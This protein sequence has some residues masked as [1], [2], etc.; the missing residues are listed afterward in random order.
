MSMR[1]FMVMTALLV[2]A[3]VPAFCIMQISVEPDGKP[4]TAGNAAVVKQGIQAALKP[5][6]LVEQYFVE[7]GRFPVANQEAGLAA[8]ASYSH[9]ALKRATV[10]RHG[11]IELIF[12]KSSGRYDGQLVM[13]PQFK[14]E[15]EG[16]VWNY[17]TNNLKGLER[18]LPGCRYVKMH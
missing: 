14:N 9:G 6:L 3:I 18:Y 2:L 4:I 5:R 16:I 17:Q 12:S 1:R 8:P 10:G 11:R 13:L 15:R 7:H